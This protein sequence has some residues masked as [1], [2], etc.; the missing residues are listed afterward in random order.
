M[1]EILEEEHQEEELTLIKAFKLLKKI[2]DK[3]EDQS[4]FDKLINVFM[5]NDLNKKHRYLLGHLLTDYYSKIQKDPMVIKLLHM[6]N[7]TNLN[8]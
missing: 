2:V 8:K 1:V 7:K 3:E 4:K 6:K 5:E